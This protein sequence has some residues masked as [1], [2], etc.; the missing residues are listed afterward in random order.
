MATVSQS[1]NQMLTNEEISLLLK[2]NEES[3]VLINEMLV[4]IATRL[5][6]IEEAIGNIPTP[7]KTYYKPVGSADHITLKDNLDYIYSRLDR[8][9]NGM[10][11]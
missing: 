3:H 2:D 6:D 8:L 4:K 7:D 5:K 11:K 9:E 1:E 10:H